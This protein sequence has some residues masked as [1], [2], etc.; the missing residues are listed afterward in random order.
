MLLPEN[1]SYRSTGLGALV[2]REETTYLLPVGCPTDSLHELTRQNYAMI[3]LRYRLILLLSSPGGFDLPTSPA[4]RNLYQRSIRPGDPR[5]DLHGPA[6]TQNLCEDNMG[7]YE[8]PLGVP[9]PPEYPPSLLIQYG[10][11]PEP[12]F[13]KGNGVPDSQLHS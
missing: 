5:P 7:K 4:W 6:D 2:I 10:R 1:L 13:N 9:G 8:G 11:E 3:A 12:Y